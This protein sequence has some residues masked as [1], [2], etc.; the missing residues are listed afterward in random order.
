M[1]N[2]PANASLLMLWVVVAGCGS[3]SDSMRVWG[4]VT[5]QGQPVDEGQIVFFPIENT[6]G[7][8][9]GTE[10]HHGRYDIEK[11]IGPRAGGTYRVE[12]TASGPETS[13]CPNASGVGHVA[14]VRSQYLPAAYNRHSQLRVEI[15]PKRKQNEYDFHLAP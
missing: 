5:F 15:S 7:P 8:S 12:I 4:T 3:G 14:A 9:T 2:K 1:T 10:I 13:Y 6:T 11:R